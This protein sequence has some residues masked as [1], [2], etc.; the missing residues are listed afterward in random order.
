MYL[1]RHGESEANVDPGVYL[2]KNDFEIELTYLG[3]EQANNCGRVLANI[4]PYS[5]AIFY[6]PFKRA[7]DT[8]EIIDRELIK[9]GLYANMIEEPLIFERI[10]GADFNSIIETDLFDRK[11]HFSFYYRPLNGESFSDCYTRVVLFFQELHRMR[12]TL[13][14][15]IIVVSHGEFIRLA[16]KYLSG[17]SIKHFIDNRSNPKNCEIIEFKF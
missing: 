7:K 4:I 1:I 17:T 10:W 16:I 15:H 12:D 13:P 2:R 6:S 8:A 14:D 11:K 3:H 5:P 9:A